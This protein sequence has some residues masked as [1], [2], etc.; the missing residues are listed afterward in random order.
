MESGGD[1]NARDSSGT[2]RLLKCLGLGMV[3]GLVCGVVCLPGWPLHPL[4]LKS[5][6]ARF[7]YRDAL[8]A[9]GDVVIVAIDDQSIRDP[10]LGRWPWDRAWHARLIRK[11]AAEKPRVI[12]FDVV[13]AEPSR[14]G[15]TD[16]Q[17][18]ARATAEAGCVVHAAYAG[19]K[20]TGKSEQ[21]V[22][23]RFQVEPGIVIHQDAA[24]QL[25]S[26]VPPL[27]EIAGAAAGTGVIAGRQDR[28]GTLRRAFFLVR[29]AKTG[30]FF[31][32]FELAVAAKGMGWDYGK[33]RFDLARQAELAPGRRIPLDEQGMAL[34]NFLGP[35][36][37]V[38]QYPVIDVLDGRYSPGT[39]RDKIVLVG[40]TAPGLQQD[41]FPVP[42]GGGMFGLEIHAQTLENILHG[43]FLRQ[44]DLSTTL[45]LAVLMALVGAMAVGLARPV[46]GFG[47]LALS[48]VVYDALAVRSF[49]Q[50]G[51]VWPMLGPNL[52]AVLAFMP[53]AVFRLATEETARRRLRNEFGRYAPPQMV[54][55][56]DAGEMQARSAGTIRPVTALFADVRG[57]TAWSASVSPHD[58]VSVLNT[59]FEGMTQLAFDVGGT[60]DNIV[61]DE[62]FITFNVLED[63]PDHVARAANLAINMIQALEDLNRR[64]LATHTLPEPMRIGIGIN[65]G[66]ALVGNLGSHIRT[67]YTVLG[68]VVNLAS[69]LQALNKELGT[70][71]LTTKDVADAVAA[72][73]QTRC[74]GM[75]NIRGHPVPVEVHEIIGRSGPQSAA[76]S[77]GPAEAGRP[78]AGSGRSEEGVV[79]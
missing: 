50:A 34:V 70:T 9:P 39:F 20:L 18:L 16:D 26:V 35:T 72:T 60:V 53:I 62:I 44:S 12:A 4:E 58:V 73:I 1:R 74:L 14:A 47:A 29:D 64:W 24:P 78:Q 51:V 61:G 63:Q 32:T 7:Q 41:F 54:A 2:R 22:A 17:E 10:R 59:Y 45:G 65:A 76:P 19:Q 46:V 13:F 40:L 5:L 55:R 71:I 15:G 66:E 42:C 79:P 68:Q 30:T 21:A 38:A 27:A 25:T 36:G 57:F 33:M 37:T 8:P 67:Q 75:Q 52:S 48:L 49:A 28:D 77:T 56:L 43:T 31:P 6:D 11:L 69:R 23:A 3:V